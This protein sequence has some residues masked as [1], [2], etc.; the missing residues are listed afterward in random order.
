[1]EGSKEMTVVIRRPFTPI[2]QMQE[3]L[4]I[5][6]LSAQILDAIKKG[7]LSSDSFSPE[8]ELRVDSDD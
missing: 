3:V 4:R 5:W 7:N 2:Q 8:F 6:A 1:M